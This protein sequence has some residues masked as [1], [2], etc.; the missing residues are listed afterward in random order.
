[1]DIIPIVLLPHLHG[2]Y[3]FDKEEVEEASKRA[4][5]L[6]YIN[7]LPDKFETMV[8]EGGNNLSGG[9][10]QRVAIARAILKDAPILILDEATSALDNKTE[11][12]VIK[13]LDNLMKNRT[14][15]A[16]AHRLSTLKSMDRIIVVDK[17]HI[18]EEGT[19]DEL[20]NKNGEFKK[21][22]KLQK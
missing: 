20:L 12:K 13:A 1:M 4:Y 6:D 11:D 5:I 17:G 7:S 9:Q 22:W 19:I 3:K 8:S 2:F 16:I 15:I 18:I 14:V 21:L 10:R